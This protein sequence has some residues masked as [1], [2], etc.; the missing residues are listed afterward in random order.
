[1][2]VGAADA[3]VAPVDA[4]IVPVGIVVVDVDIAVA[5]F[6]A[7]G[8]VGVVP[9]AVVDVV[10]DLG[11]VTPGGVAVVVVAGSLEAPDGV[12]I[13]IFYKLAPAVLV[14]GTEIAFPIAVGEVV[15]NVLVV[16]V[17]PALT[18]AQGESCEHQH[19]CVVEH[20]LHNRISYTL[21]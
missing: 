16:I 9:P 1:M 13:A 15:C 21:R 18:A 20:L 17:L 7:E 11:T 5:H 8:A 2:E 4:H 10:I 6:P 19:H 12:I 3:V 14:V